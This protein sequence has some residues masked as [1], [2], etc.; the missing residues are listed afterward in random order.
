MS[1]LFHNTLI[2]YVKNC[3][4]SVLLFIFESGT[5]QKQNI[6]LWYSTVYQQTIR[7]NI[8]LNENWNKQQGN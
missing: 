1:V 2:F 4:K 8:I 3:L 7:T 6:I 5:K